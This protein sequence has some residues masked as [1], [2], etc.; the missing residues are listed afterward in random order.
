[1]AP[2][3]G[4]CYRRPMSPGDERADGRLD[5]RARDRRHERLLDE[6]GRRV[7]VLDGA[8]G[9]ELSRFSLTEADVRGAR[10]ASHP[11]DLRENCD[12]LCL[13][14]PDVVT[15]LHESYL[16]AG[17]DLLK[18][19]TFNA[20]AIALRPYAL[21]EHVFEL[22]RAAAHLARNAADAWSERE[23]ARPRWVAGVMGPTAVL[24]SR[25]SA[26][27]SAQL[28]AAYAEQVHGLITGG[29]DL[30]LLETVTDL[31]NLEAALAGSADAF[32]AM[33]VHLPLVISATVDARGLLPSGAP[34]A[35]FV[36]KVQTTAPVRPLALGLNCCAGARSIGPHATA[37][38]RLHAGRVS[39]HP[40]AGLPNPGPAGAHPEGPADTSSILA[41]LAAAGLVNIVGGCC[42]TTPTHIAALVR[43]VADVR[44]RGAT[45]VTTQPT[46]S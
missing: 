38:A 27:T 28:R 40:S 13:T 15:R 44:P 2:A 34:L 31:Q 8:A 42:G 1:M 39:C 22:N 12:V 4:H 30:L 23:P 14:R 6:L 19:N 3:G 35:A 29:A 36:E 11:V 20:T 46:G 18:T 45:A 32:A 17:A 24:L 26:V 5:H 16:D 41:E 9:T 37:L 10:F 43:A 33:E 25:A 21:S 7:L